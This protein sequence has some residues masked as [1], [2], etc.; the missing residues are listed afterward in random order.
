MTITPMSYLNPRVRGRTDP[1]SARQ[2]FTSDQLETY[3]LGQMLDREWNHCMVHQPAGWVNTMA[4]GEWHGMPDGYAKVYANCIGRVLAERPGYEVTIYSGLQF[5]SAHSIYGRPRPASG[6]GFIGEPGWADPKNPQHVRGIR[7]LTVQPWADL[8]VTGWVFD[9]GSK[10]PDAVRRWKR[11][12][13]RLV[14]RVGLE[15]IPWN[16]HRN[17]VD[18]NPA[19]RWGLEYYALTRFRSGKPF[20]ETV[21][22]GV[23][24]YV[25]M[26]HPPIPSVDELVGMMRR[27]WTPM[28]LVGFDPLVHDAMAAMGVGR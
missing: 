23:T 17:R 25:W 20:L 6:R 14:P 4:G 8:G 27:G 2:Y 5:Y 24:A 1:D 12:L 7:D 9:S 15:A 11:H 19:K 3:L 10:D 16:D 26:T 13:R 21:P 28:G 22:D 18:W